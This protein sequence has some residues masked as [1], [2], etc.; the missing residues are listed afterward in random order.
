MGM[1]SL[2]ARFCLLDI[3]TLAEGP[4]AMFKVPDIAHFCAGRLLNGEALVKGV[5]EVAS[6]EP[7]TAFVA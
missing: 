5:R 7:E 1:F 2:L 3:P 6:M 4:V